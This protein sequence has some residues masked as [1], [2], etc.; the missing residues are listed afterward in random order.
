MSNIFRKPAQ[1]FEINGEKVLISPLKLGTLLKVQ[2]L[3]QSVSEAFAKLRSVM[4]NE[5]EKV[6]NS[7]PS[8]TE[9][10]K[11]ASIYTMKEVHHAPEISLVSL[12]I[13]NK[14]EGVKA[15]FDCLFQNNLLEDVLIQSVDRFKHIP[16]G[17][18]LDPTNEES[19]DLP[20]ALEI[21]LAIVEVNMGGFSELGKFSRL[22]TSF[23][24]AVKPQPEKT[25]KKD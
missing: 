18:L 25:K 10:D 19:L 15:L 22:L 3:A 24:A 9:K 6:T 13:K 12:T 11:D 23:Q 2:D 14:Q 16:K 21:L 17:T 1:E 5:Y 7:S 4:I 8:P 20:T